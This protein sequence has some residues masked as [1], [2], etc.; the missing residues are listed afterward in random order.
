[1]RIIVFKKERSL[2]FKIVNVKKD[3]GKLRK[4]FRLMSTKEF[5]VM[6]NPRLDPVLEG[7]KCYKKWNHFLSSSFTFNQWK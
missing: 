2:F 6:P 5:N 1:M 7:G 3:K 4:C